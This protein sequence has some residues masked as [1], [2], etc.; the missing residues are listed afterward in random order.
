MLAHSPPLYSPLLLPFHPPLSHFSLLHSLP[1]S[2]LHSFTPFLP[3]SLFYSLPPS[4]TLLLPLSLP[5]FLPPSLP[6]FL[7]LSL[8]QT[9]IC[10]QI[11]WARLSLVTPTSW[12]LSPGTIAVRFYCRMFFKFSSVWRLGWEEEVRGG[13]QSGTLGG[14]V[15]GWNVRATGMSE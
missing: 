10:W 4:F 12:T 9:H 5:P 8:P 6:P 2:L 15:K 3:P 11:D 7:P 14:S 1:S 13:R